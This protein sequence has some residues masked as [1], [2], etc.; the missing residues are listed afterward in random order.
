MSNTAIRTAFA[1]WKAAFAQVTL[2]ASLASSVI[3]ARRAFL[4]LIFVGACIVGENVTTASSSSGAGMRTMVLLGILAILCGAFA[5][6]YLYAKPR[7]Q[8]VHDAIFTYCDDSMA[9]P[10]SNGENSKP[11]LFT[12]SDIHKMLGEKFNGGKDYMPSKVTV[13]L[14]GHI[15]E[16]YSIMAGA[17]IKTYDVHVIYTANKPETAA[18]GRSEA[19]FSTVVL[20][21][22]PKADLLPQGKDAD[23]NAPLP[24]PPTPGGAGG[25]GGGGRRPGG[26]AATSGEKKEEE[27]KKE[28]EKPAEEKKPE[29]EKKE[30]A[31]KKEETKPET[32]PAETPPAETPAAE[33][34]P[35]AEKKPEPETPKK[36]EP[37][38]DPPATPEEKPAEKPEPKPEPPAGEPK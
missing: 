22:Y 33:A 6:D 11:K 5:Y 7:A 31:E 24:P 8:E 1:V 13:E 17:V 32:P 18:E 4:I 27:P 23:K 26:E 15:V 12:P 35:E 36:E 21:E 19:K 34:K 3:E 2:A 37:A 10:T 30:E 28:E 25:G 14:P 20:G 38:A 29:G 16:T 9:K